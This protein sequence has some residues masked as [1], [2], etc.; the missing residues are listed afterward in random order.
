LAAD[1]L[2][3][4][5]NDNHAERLIGSIRGIALIMLLCWASGTFIHRLKANQKYYNEARTHLSLGAP[6]PRAVQAIGQTLT[7]RN[8]FA[9]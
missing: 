6:I 5:P 7:P 8:A 2:E 1:P 4:P 9:Y 3:N